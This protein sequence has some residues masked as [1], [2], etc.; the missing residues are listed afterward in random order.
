M[1][2][3]FQ[4]VGQT[5]GHY[6]ILE[7][8]GAG[9]MGVVYRARDEQLERAVALKVLPAGMLADEAARKR[10]RKE[11]LA[12]AKLNHPNVETIHEF[13]TEN[14]VDFLVSEYIP[15]VSLDVK[16]AA[17]AL[18]E[19]E[20]VQL[21]T[22]LAAGLEAAH[23]Q[24]VVHRDL[25]PGNLR[26]A[27][28]GRL[29]ILDFGLARL[30]IPEDELAHTATLTQSQDITGT[31]PYMAPEQLRGDIAD[32]RADLWA[33]G[34]VLY[35]MVTS[36]RPFPET[37]V[38]RLIDAILHQAPKPPKAVNNR[39]SSGLDRVIL[40]ALQKNCEQ[41]YQS[42]KEL[43]GDLERLSAG[44]TPVAARFWW[45]RTMAMGAVM[46]MLL[47][48][49]ASW[50]LLRKRSQTVP[51]PIRVRRSVAVLGFKNLSGRPAEAWLST[52]LSEM[53]TTELAVGE[54][55]RTIPGENVA[56][57]KADLSLPETDSL[58][59]DTLARIRKNLGTDFVVIGS[60]LD[61]GKE[62][63]QQIRLD[64]RLQ[65]AVEGNTIVT[66]SQKG[67]EARLDDLVS[68]TGALLREKLGAGRV[69]AKEISL[70]K[71]SLPSNPEALRMYSEGLARLRT[72][73]ALAARDLLEKATVWDP[74]YP[75]AH[76]TLAA[77]WSALG[78]EEKAK[79]QAQKAYELSTN[80]S[81]EERLWVEGELRETTG[82]WDKAVGIYQTLVDF[83]PD[84]LEYGL[85]LAAAQ[86]S[87]G[88]ARDA[89]ATVV[90]LRRFLPPSGDDPRI[91]LTEARAAMSLGDYGREQTMAAR[92]AEKA[93]SQGLR[94]ILA[95]ALAFEGWAF[96]NL[97]E[98]A[99][100]EAAYEQ[101]KRIYA[102]AGDRYQ[103]A[104]VL[105]GQASILLEQGNFAGAIK[106][107]MEALNIFREV[108][109][110]RQEANVLNN[111]GLVVK[112]QSNLG[113][114]RRMFQKSMSIFREIS[115]QAGI[116]MVLN[117]SGLVLMDEGHLAAARVQFEEAFKIDSQIGK[118]NGAADALNNIAFVLLRQGNLSEAKRINEKA[119]TAFREIH[120]RNGEA[121]AMLV[122]GL[123]AENQ[124]DLPRAKSAFDWSLAISRETGG[125]W[126][127]AFN[128]S[129]SA[130][131]PFYEGDL[132]RARLIYE[133]A[134]RLGEGI[135][136]E[137]IVAESRKALAELSIEEGH[138]D[139]AEPL[140]RKA[141]QEFGK[142]GLLPNRAM[143]YAVLSRSLLAEG[144]PQDALV[145][146]SRAESILARSDDLIVRL[147]VATIGARI[148][149]TGR[150][151]KATLSLE[152][153]IAD[154]IKIGCI[155]CQFEA[156]LALGEIEM[157][158]GQVTA[159]RA[160]LERLEKDARAKG[161]GLIARKAAVARS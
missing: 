74:G 4:L 117:N 132:A 80:L 122:S 70:V 151:T 62:S 42:G 147:K 22:Q 44:M 23:L 152:T 98:N 138:P 58:A 29:K 6:R 19:K 39:I 118:K 143:A 94:M 15:G 48:G 27:P 108:G 60:Y 142:L 111:I 158:S 110:K 31:L 46:I 128:L 95:D 91:D 86:T 85:R 100:A 120:Y 90:A 119:L 77:V 33:A 155:P 25:K 9:G 61:L 105:N 121:L 161:F 57:M 88:K 45:V 67:T 2:A 75:L 30:A 36:E 112:N 103:I 63:D 16:L 35:E 116:A 55:L 54:Q 50:Y 83:F 71:A 144:K 114:A 109:N 153:T 104:V 13:G 17:G 160:R 134:L 148:H 49:T 37:Q 140:A 32:A 93:N 53:L 56:R 130:D 92:A 3:P 11:A 113:E 20:V 124:G 137:D 146:I 1:A 18:P 43:R 10:F 79:E 65:D 81:R 41:R 126:I 59:K 72:F 96:R 159:G 136:A 139:K 34:A 123:I 150:P 24:G 101:A 135:G 21:G 69:S 12:L 127:S 141:L 68:S 102:I 157:K 73:E 84:N 64:L 107:Y 99:K 47:A 82:E 40:K 76:S 87:A 8:I 97:G 78:Y 129:C 106:T 133:Q 5:L 26:V 145:A 115:N 52:A 51:V 89:L 28:D 154:A 149:A 125:K 156:R 66:I 38:P 14:G 7:Q 131:I